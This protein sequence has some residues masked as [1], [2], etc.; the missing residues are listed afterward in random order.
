MLASDAYRFIMYH[1]RAIES[2]PLQTYA[3]ALLFSPTGSLVRQIFKH[4]EPAWV[5]I[6]PAMGDSWSACLQTFEGHNNEVNSVAFSH[7]STKLAS[8]SDDSTVKVWDASNGTCLQ[9]LES[10]CSWNKSVAFSHD[11]TK[12]AL[13]LWNHTIKVWDVSSGAC[14]HTLEGHSS[15]INS[16]AFSYDSTKLAS[17]SDDRTVKVWDA[18]SG[19]CLQTL[20]GHTNH[21]K[22]VAFSHDSTKLASA[23][24]DSTV[25]VWDASNGACLQTLNVGQA[26]R[27][28]IFN[29]TNS[30][31][32]TE[33][34]TLRID[35]LRSS[36]EIA[37]ADPER[38][39]D[40]GIG[41]STDNT[42]IQH[43][44]KNVLWIPSEYRPLCA[45]V[46]GTTIGIGVGSGRVWLCRISPVDVH[47]YLKQSIEGD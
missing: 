20:E 29:S 2:S 14:L 15:C 32:F 40:P 8:A 12:L 19:T 36:S 43:D 1:K 6:K 34:G 5:T 26:L 45:T 9:T 17:A 31:L 4:E 21:V 3:S 46:Y 37:I 42:W 18:S 23:S 44:G 47:T 41:F 30:C 28:L 35:N 24:R 7:D 27:S 11:S 13:A 16:V 38:P 25:K 39:L 10:H 22:S 33:I